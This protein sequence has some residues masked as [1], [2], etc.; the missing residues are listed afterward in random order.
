VTGAVDAGLGRTLVHE[1]IRVSFGGEEHD[2]AHS[3]TRGDILAIAVDKLAELRDAGFKTFVDPRPIELGRDPELY[4]Q[5][6]Q[7]S[8]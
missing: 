4:A 3:V 5:I 2:R 6:S 7:R 1:H 8:A